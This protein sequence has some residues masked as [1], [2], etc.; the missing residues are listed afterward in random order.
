[1]SARRE[2]FE[3]QGFL[4]PVRLFSREQCRAVQ[5]LLAAAPVPPDWDKGNAAGSRAWFAIGA[6]PAIVDLV[7]ELIGDDVMLWGARLVERAPRQVHPWH[8]D[9]ETSDPAAGSVSVWIG[10]ENTNRLSS[11]Q[12]I[13][14]S[15]RFGTTLQERAARAGA[16]RERTTAEE[17]RDWARA[18]D[19]ASELVRVD[20]GDGEAIVFD[21]RL[22]HGS[23]NTNS[24][25]V[26]T[27]LLLQYAVPGRRIRIPDL[28]KLDFPFRYLD[29]RPPCVMVQGCAGET[30][31]RIVSPP[32]LSTSRVHRLR[33]P[34]DADPVS[35]WRRYPVAAGPSPCMEHLT[36]H[37][38]VLSPGTIPHPPH[39][40]IEEEILIVLDGAVE[41][42][43]VEP[44]G[45]RRIEP[46]AAG[47]LVYYPAWQRHTIRNP[48]KEDA[49][50][51]MFKWRNG[52]PRD[53]PGPARI[54]PTTIARAGVANGA[55]ARAPEEG[56]STRCVFEG[57]TG[58]LRWLHCHQTR[59]DQGAGY[60]PHVDPY[61]VALLLLAGSVETLD[62]RLEP[63]D[64]AFFAAGEP[65]GMRNVGDEPAS[66]L[67]V[68]FHATARNSLSAT[69]REIIPRALLE[70][71]P[72]SVNRLA[73]RAL[74]RL[75]F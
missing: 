6:L 42:V 5:R 73:R 68:E 39:R 70:R 65:H 55:P 13:S 56:R 23:D 38:S 64:I 51:C 3:E 45:E 16:A 35:G 19:P 9:I 43:I 67:V 53:E 34:L 61:D 28:S 1:M 58:H 49:T 24:K 62:H 8:T 10:L 11:L 31:N 66:Y 74:D 37:V 33:L 21:G 7:T 26:R 60:L 47:S 41:L 25:G 57:P 75:P 36:C 71:V 40:H 12:V 4:A 20:S 48:G 32:P 46:L 52:R 2:R 30:P 14:R 22:W 29:P 69:L 54:L 50:Y 44:D 17:V 18:L 27:A 59:L 63:H 15:H 72:E